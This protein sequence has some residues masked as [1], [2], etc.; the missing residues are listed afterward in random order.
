MAKF[1]LKQNIHL[2]GT[3]HG[4]GSVVELTAAQAAEFADIVE[5]HDGHAKADKK[6]ETSAPAGET[7]PE[8]LSRLNKT[9]LT[10]RLADL[11]AAVDPNASKAELVAQLTELTAAK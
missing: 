1:L 11:G 4:F 6:A 3:F 8:D 7:A 5:A 2:D 10:D 9:Q